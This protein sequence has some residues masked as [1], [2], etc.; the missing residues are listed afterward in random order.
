MPK[1]VIKKKPAKKN[2]K[3]VKS[4][5]AK[6]TKPLK[7]SDTKDKKA[8]I[9]KTPKKTP[10]TKLSTKELK[11]Y[12][13]KLIQIKDQTLDEYKKISEYRSETSR[14][15]LS[16]SSSGYGMHLADAAA[17]NFEREFSLNL[18][19]TEAQI[20]ANVDDALK[21]IETKEFGVCQSCFKPIPKIRLN[22]LPYV[23]LCIKCKE[24]HENSENL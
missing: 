11:F 6:K 7:I 2:I 8:N 4:K 14:D 13:E 23:K 1:T 5:T 17:E 19:S 9:V 18:A 24:K 3:I 12:K 20:I 15:E 10:V 22:A 21:R 16:R